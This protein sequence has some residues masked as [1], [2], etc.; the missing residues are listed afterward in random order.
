MSDKRRPEA[1]GPMNERGMWNG[2]PRS[3]GDNDR[4]FPGL[5]IPAGE[6]A[7]WIDEFKASVSWN[8]NIYCIALSVL[9]VSL[10]ALLGIRKSPEG[11]SV[12]PDAAA[13]TTSGPGQKT[14]VRLRIRH[15]NDLADAPLPPSRLFFRPTNA[16]PPQPPPPHPPLPPLAIFKP[17]H[18]FLHPSRERSP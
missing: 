15:R 8:G 17:T 13:T 3:P 18:F 7:P 6:N 4:Y 5:R 14:W 9:S 2:L 11:F 10:S 12:P 16:D 1:A